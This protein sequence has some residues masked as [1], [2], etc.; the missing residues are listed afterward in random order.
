MPPAGRYELMVGINEPEAVIPSGASDGAHGF[1]MQGFVMQGFVMH[2]FVKQ[3]V[4]L[5][6]KPPARDQD[7]RT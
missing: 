6:V 3:G 1:V 5:G 2:G 4:R 7:D